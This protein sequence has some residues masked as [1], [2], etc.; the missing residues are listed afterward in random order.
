MHYVSADYPDG[1]DIGRLLM[2]F[3]PKNITVNNFNGQYKH[4]HFTATG[5]L[6]NLLAYLFRNQPLE[7]ALA[8]KA[9]HINLNEWMSDSTEATTD[10]AAI[11]AFEVPSNIDFTLTATAD[12]VHYDNFDI[13]NA[14]GN[15]ILKDE[16]LYLNDVSGNALEGRF[17]VNG[18]YSTKKSSRKPDIYL[19]YDVDSLDI[20]KTFLTFNT[21]Q[22]L[23]PVARFLTGTLSSNLKL[24]GR[25]DE[26]M[27]PVLNTL[28]G[29][30]T[31]LLLNGILN[32]SASVDKLA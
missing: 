3:D 27:E 18:S 11:T 5:M 26:H 30:G 24:T 13:T 12:K 25:L 14:S 10:T 21:V 22:K 23:M 29:T 2:T 6:N 16:T 7:G 8:V 15:V 4:T 28:T 32:N 31:V 20:Q 17:A 9:D 19:A 1:I